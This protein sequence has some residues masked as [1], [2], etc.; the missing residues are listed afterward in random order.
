MTTK[1]TSTELIT[2]APIVELA[3]PRRTAKTDA[4]DDAIVAQWLHGRPDRTV[5]AYGADARRFREFAGVPLYAVTLGDLQGYADLL[6]RRG[7][8]ATSQGCALA[9]V[10]SLL[11]FA[12]RIGAIPANVGVVVHLPSSQDR[13]AERI[14]SQ[15]DVLR[16]IALETNPRN[17]LALAVMYGAA[18]RVSEVAGLCWRD[19]QQRDEGQVQLTVW[20]KGAKTRA[21]VL[22]LHLSQELE[23][24][25][26]EP[27]G[28][29]FVGRG[30][31]PLTAGQLWRV[32][33]QAGK[34]AGIP[35][36]SPHWLRH[37]HAS[38]ALDAGAPV[39]VVRDTLGHSS[40]ATTSRY[41]HARPGT[42]SAMFLPDV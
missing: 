24:M 41:L 34:R 38:H 9:A 26:G 1:A 3:R 27:D 35:A 23:A 33:K 32:V 4:T 22:P 37:S 21:V 10:K 28:A 17:H 31:Q 12:F 11:T 18:L 6:E 13:L 14:L 19:V 5:R 42:S 2:T 15:A 8:A 40:I 16:M 25:R 36:L 20:G 30:G 29:V 7:L 39:S